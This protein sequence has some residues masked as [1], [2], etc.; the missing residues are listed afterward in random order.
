MRILLVTIPNS[1]HLN[2]LCRAAE[3]Y[4]DQHEFGLLLVDRK[5]TQ[6]PIKGLR[7]PVYT[8]SGSQQ[9]R[10]TSES[11]VLFRASELLAEC[12]WTAKEFGP[13]LIIYDFC[14]IEGRF[15]ADLLQVPAWASIP[16]MIGPFENNE[17]RNECLS[18]PL[19][20]RGMSSLRREFGIDVDPN[21]VEMI[22]NCLH[23]PAQRNLLWSYP[24]LTPTNFRKNRAPYTYDFVGYLGAPSPPLRS[25]DNPFV[26]IS[27]GTE[28]MDNMWIRQ[29]G[30]RE[31]IRDG[32]NAL[33]ELWQPRAI[34]VLF[35]TQRKK[36]FRKIPPGWTVRDFVD[37]PSA[38]HA[39][40]AF[41]THGGSNS[42]HEAVLA[43][44]PMAVVPF[45]GDQHLVAEQA[46]A[47]GVGIHVAGT[48]PELRRQG[49]QALTGIELAT[50]IDDAITRLLA[51]TDIASS[52]GR[53]ALECVPLFDE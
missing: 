29:R 2:I 3:Q 44:T 39:A 21:E 19:N 40:T 20:Q 51:R 31:S 23:I 5:N 26:Y 34:E 18:S 48:H 30:V 47:L 25:D 10:N 37:Q 8:I 4:S 45:F 9:F 32:M 52:F 27:F 16:G 36:V 14:A 50:R 46:A 12:L 38:L 43:Q 15:V 42:F 22:S 6:A 7:F 24:S 41:V 53:I 49:F 33:A 17:Y 11:A 35:S 28:V 1:G 13:D